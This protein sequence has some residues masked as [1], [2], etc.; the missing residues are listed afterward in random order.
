MCVLFLMEAAKKV[1]SA[2]G[3]PYQSGKQTVRDALKDILKIADYIVENK[4]TKEVSGRKSPAFEDKCNI[5][6]K[7]LTTTSWLAD[8][9]SRKQLQDVDIEEDLQ[10]QFEVLSE[11][12]IWDTI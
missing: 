1:D 9:L 6:W 11:Y 7:K 3:A 8:I 10:S 4:V 5:G 2:F 12:E